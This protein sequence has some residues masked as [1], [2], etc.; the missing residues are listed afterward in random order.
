MTAMRPPADPRRG[1]VNTSRGFLAGRPPWAW[2][3]GD[4]R[5]D[6]EPSAGDLWLLLWSLPHALSG[7]P[8][9]WAAHR[10][11]GLALSV[12]GGLWRVFYNVPSSFLCC[13][14]SSSGDPFP[15]TPTQHLFKPPLIFPGA[16]TRSQPALRCD[17]C[18]GPLEGLWRRQ[19]A[20]LWLLSRAACRDSRPGDGPPSTTLFP[21]G[22]HSP[23]LLASL[24][25]RGLSGCSI[26]SRFRLF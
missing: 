17:R 23:H 3:Y 11:S 22:G 14:V 24:L 20:G 5:E 21:V 19:K 18:P 9:R 6:T 26:S 2:P 7:P 15:S 25:S 10:P 4:T 12:P 16:P 13:P 1:P 8:G